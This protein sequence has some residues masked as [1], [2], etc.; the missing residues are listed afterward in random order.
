MTLA[1]ATRLTGRTPSTTTGAA[2][3]IKGKNEIIIKSKRAVY[4]DVQGAMIANAVAFG[5]EIRLSRI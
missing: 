4:H 3:S 2:A 1:T 5:F